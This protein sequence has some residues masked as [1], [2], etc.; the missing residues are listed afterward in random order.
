[1]TTM[2]GGSV[3]AAN[4]IYELGESAHDSVCRIE[5]AGAVIVAKVVAP[6]LAG[7]MADALRL[8]LE[9]AIKRHGP[10]VAVVDEA[11]AVWSADALYA[12]GSVAQA[13]R[14]QGGK[15]AVAG[16]DRPTRRA[17]RALGGADGAAI[18]GSAKAA[19]KAAGRGAQKNAA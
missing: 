19:V 6:R 8:G 17:F 2:A 12:L 10:R 13:C 7:G 15:M 16:L 9:R 18:C 4:G 5:H 11:G 1:M 14:K 3:Q